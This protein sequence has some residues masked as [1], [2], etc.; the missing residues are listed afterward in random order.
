MKG[1]TYQEKGYLTNIITDKAIDW[2]EN[3]RDKN[4][5]F[6]LLIHH[7]ACHRNWLPELKY[8]HEYEDQT[9]PIPSTFYDN[10]EAALLPERKKWKSANTWTSSTTRRCIVQASIR[11]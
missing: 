8:L 1:E 4:K 11:R 7:K 3:K 9:F 10:Y 2:L 5:P 6:L